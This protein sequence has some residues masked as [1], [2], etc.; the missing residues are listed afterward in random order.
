MVR[1][2]DSRER[3]EEILGLIIESYIRES[4]PIS[5][6]YLC[7]ECRLNYSSATVRNIMVSLEK[8]GLLS[9]IYTSSGRVP[10]QEGFKH[11]VEHF[12][13]ED[14]AQ[15]YPVT[16]DF[17]SL[18]SLGMDEVVNYTLDALAQSSGY[19]SLVAI[20]GK[21]EKLFFRGRGMRFILDQPEFEDIR[22]LKHIFYALE[23]RMEELQQLLFNCIDDK[24]RILIGDDIG[25]DEISNCSLIA[26]GLREN[27]FE[28]ALGLLG[29]MRMNYTKAV[30]CLNSVKGQL[31]EVIEEFA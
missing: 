20:S 16:L 15:N 22:R 3:E 12:S 14:V 9:H 18:P 25:F 26:S 28:F 21:D 8:K 19:T 17:T 5:S 27:Q 31:K 23:V 30:S 1:F 6:G 10:T 2:V 13:E 4:R 11:Y 7:K 29:P 24:V